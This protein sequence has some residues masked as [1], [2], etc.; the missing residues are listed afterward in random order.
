MSYDFYTEKIA[1]DP[2]TSPEILK[3]ILEMGKEEEVVFDPNCPPD[4][5]ADM[6]I[7]LLGQGDS[8]F[9][10]E[11]GGD[12]FVSFN[13][14]RGGDKFACEYTV[15]ALNC[16]PEVLEMIIKRKNDDYCVVKEAVK[17]PNCPSEALE[18]VLEKF[19]NYKS[20]NY[21]I[22]K[23]A[24]KNPNCPQEALMGLLEKVENK[25]LDSVEYFVNF[26]DIFLHHEFSSTILGEVLERFGEKDAKVA[27]NAVRNPNCPPEALRKVLERG[28][29][30]Y[31]SLY[32]AQNK[33]CPP[34]TL[35]MVL[36]RGN[37]DYK[38]KDRTNERTLRIAK[39]GKVN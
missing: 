36:G 27:R 5:L 35:K 6:L 4:M 22:V 37:N 20:Y 14:E 9:I 26:V 12:K 21:F 30:D 23:E 1:Q 16:S 31:V 15:G 29:N 33:N 25:E 11:R 19:N 28:K 38:M 32:A 17:N 3:K 13:Y 8:K 24:V 2:N 10:Y 39:M 34:E 18:M 7:K